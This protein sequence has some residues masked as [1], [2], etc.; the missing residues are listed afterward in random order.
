MNWHRIGVFLAYFLVGVILL[1]AFGILHVALSPLGI[2]GSPRHLLVAA[3]EISCLVIGI[4][5]YR[6]R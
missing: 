5:L 1:V 6:W 2:E 4:L 3:V